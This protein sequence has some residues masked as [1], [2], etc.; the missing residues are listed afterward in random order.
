MK[1]YNILLVF[2]AYYIVLFVASIYMEVQSATSKAEEAYNTIRQA[3]NVTLAQTQAVDDFLVHTNEESYKTLVPNDSGT[4]FEEMDMYK[5][6]FGI[7]SQVEG[8]KDEIFNKL[9]QEGQAQN[10][11]N[12]LMSKSTEVKTPIRFLNQNN[13]FQ[14]GYMPTS[15]FL[16][17]DT[18]DFDKSKLNIT[19]EGGGD[20]GYQLSQTNYEN[21]NLDNH[22]KTTDGVEFF[23]TPLSSGITF[24]NK[25][26]TAKLF[27]ANMDIIMRGQYRGKHNLNNPEGGKG[28]L[29]GATYGTNVTNDGLDR[30][31]PV[32]NGIFTYLKGEKDSESHSYFGIEPDVEYKVF[33]MYDP[34]NDKIMERVFGAYKAGYSTK[35]EYLKSL[36]AEKLNPVT[37]TP[38]RKK[39][40]VVAKVTF[41]ADVILPFYSVVFRGIIDNTRSDGNTLGIT[42]DDTSTK[43]EGGTRRI[44]YTTFFAVAP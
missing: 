22:T 15:V 11:Y 38:Y 29:K 43:G 3:A 28:V 26:M 10:D 7:D 1:F 40:I 44:S 27:S 5:Y 9:F 21:Y 6:L 24:L 14:W 34:Q 25:E 32:N 2:L 42:T 13:L 31:N 37:N 35:A 41:Y 20:I 8:K 17:L 33:D 19:T 16:G 4:D 12:D 39:P 18:F 23:N 36:D 30:Y